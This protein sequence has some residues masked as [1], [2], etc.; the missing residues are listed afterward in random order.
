MLDRITENLI[1]VLL[2][3]VAAVRPEDK[4]MFARLLANLC[5]AYLNDD[6]VGFKIILDSTFFSEEWKTAMFRALWSDERLRENSR[7]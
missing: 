6:A 2:L 7:Q 5:Q 3:K 4:A 1:P